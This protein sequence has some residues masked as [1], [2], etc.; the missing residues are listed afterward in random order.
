MVN[1]AHIENDKVV[2][3]SVWEKAPKAK[4]LLIVPDNL[5]VN[6]GDVLVDGKLVNHIHNSKTDK[7]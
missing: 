2:N 1:V 3:I 4:N 7:E 5:D 6:I